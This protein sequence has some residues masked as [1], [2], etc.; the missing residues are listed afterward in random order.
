MIEEHLDGHEAP[1]HG[2]PLEEGLELV[3]ILADCH[4]L[5][6]LRFWVVGHPNVP[7]LMPVL[8]HVMLLLPDVQAPAAPPVPGADWLVYPHC[9]DPVPVPPATP[10]V[11]PMPPVLVFVL[12]VV[13]PPA[14]VEIEPKY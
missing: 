4:A 6:A 12:A 5:L 11:P 10:S 14:D 2:A 7:S 3:A 1:A 9:V 8:I 13:S